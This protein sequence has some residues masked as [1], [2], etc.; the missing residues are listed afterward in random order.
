MQPETKEKALQAGVKAVK[1]EPGNLSYAI[2]YGYVLLNMGKTADAKKLQ[3]RIV[4]AAKTPEEQANAEMLGGALTSRENYDHQVAENQSRAKQ[5]AEEAAAQQQTTGAAMHVAVASASEAGSPAPREHANQ[6]ELAVEGVIVSAECNQDS[7]GR[8]TLSVN[9]LG[10]KFFYSSL[11]T[12]QVVGGVE[13]K[14]TPPPCSDW[15]GK[16]ARFYFY[17]TKTKPYAGELSTLMLL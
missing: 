11:S 10:M 2:N 14:G 17:S 9:H 1:L 16:K 7:L 12:L 3:E 6:Q 13:G 4:K 5:E 8:V 15:K